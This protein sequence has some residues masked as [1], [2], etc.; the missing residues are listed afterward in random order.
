MRAQS[1]VG[2]RPLQAGDRMHAPNNFGGAGRL[3]S[4]G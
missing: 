2:C 1:N 4:S 3:S